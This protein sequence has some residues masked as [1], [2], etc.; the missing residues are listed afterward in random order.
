MMNT[1]KIEDDPKNEDDPD[2]HRNEDNSK[3]EDK[4]T[5]KYNI[6]ALFSLF[7]DQTDALKSF[8][9][10]LVQS[11]HCKRNKNRVWKDSYGEFSRSIFC[12]IFC[13]LVSDERKYQFLLS[14]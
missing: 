4:G 9:N 10:I 6:N 8:Q 12:S 13:L 14:S 1:F 11:E 3:N 2:R 5:F 7:S